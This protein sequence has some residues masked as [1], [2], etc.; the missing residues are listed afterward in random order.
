MRPSPTPRSAP[1]ALLVLALGPGCGDP[2]GGGREAK[3][4]HVL[5]VTVDTLRADHLA[6]YGGRPSVSPAIDALA[7]EGTLF[8]R[9]HAPTGMTLASMTAMFTSKWPDETGVRSNLHRLRDEEWTLAER[10]KDAGFRC[11]GFTAN[12]VLQ[13]DKSGIDQGFDAH[14]R[15]EDEPWLT[16]LAS[17]MLVEEFGNDPERRDFLWVH[18]MDPHQPYQR[19]E[20]WATRF[21]PSYDGPFDAEEE[22]L[23]RIFVD[24]VELTPRDVQHV[25][26]VYDSQI[27]RVDQ[28]V[29]SI[30]SALEKSGHAEETL[31]VFSADHGEDLYDHN[32]YFYHAN[33]IYGSVTHV[34]LVF[35]QPGRVPAGA[36][37]DDLVE[38]ID[39][40]PTILAWL[41]LDP[42]AGDWKSHPRGTD[43]GPAMTSGAAVG[44]DFAFAQIAFHVYAI[45]SPGWFYVENPRGYMPRSIPKEGEYV[46]AERELYDLGGDPDEQTNVLAEHPDVADKLA[47]ALRAWKDDL[48]SV[49]ATEQDLTDED[50]ARLEALGYLGG[51]EDDGE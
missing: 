18:Y 41:G 23:Q 13:P 10:L 39:V 36:R 24:K 31:V 38:L 50:R 49:D 26:A 32:R 29:R 34:P 30:L 37:V 12:G 17:K 9:C 47:K 11:R 25:E 6:T 20:P 19:R 42:T 33:S 1:L 4:K 2:D 43:L 27:R 40:M 5:L 15:I 28:F 48:I 7:A 35:R 44:K 3:A 16:H 51:G 21:D 14:R 8:E 46:I 22:T 45:R